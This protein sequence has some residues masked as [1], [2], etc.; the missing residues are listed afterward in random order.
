VASKPPSKPL[1]SLPVV[2]TAALVLAIGGGVWYLERGRGEPEK[3]PV[4]TADAKA[5]VRNLGLSGVSMKATENAIH[6]AVIE[7]EGKITNNGDRHLKSVRLSCIFHDAY[8]QVVLKERVEIVRARLGGL[9]PGETK[10]FRLPFDSLPQSW[11]QG[12]PQLVI[13]EIIFG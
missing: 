6:Q 8:G 13:A 9:K 5:Y 3:G 11:N 2:L 4:L 10:E 1:F 7:I 12:M